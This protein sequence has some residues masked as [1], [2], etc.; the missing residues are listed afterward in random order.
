[1]NKTTFRLVLVAGVLAIGASALAVPR[2]AFV[3]KP[4]N[5]VAQLVAHARTDSVVRDRYM[6]HFRLDRETMLAYLGSLHMAKLA[7]DGA[8]GIFNVHSDGVLRS[9]VRMMKKGTLVFAD[10]SGR[11]ILV[12]A[13]GNPMVWGVPPLGTSASVS[14]PSGERETLLGDATPVELVAETMP[15]VTPPNATAP[16]PTEPVMP[17]I[18]TGTVRRSDSLLPL[19]ALAG[20]AIL[21]SQKNDKD[22]PPPVPE[23][24]SMIALAV[25]AGSIIAKRRAKK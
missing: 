6:R 18:Q 23:P 25:G 14:N 7:A 3:R 15:G 8:Y 2:G 4:V 21:L 13:C 17:Q 1:M 16:T 5:S 10:S 9:T 20:G 24:A 12:K 22:C 19:V 11:P